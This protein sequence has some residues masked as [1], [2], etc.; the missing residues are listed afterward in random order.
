MNPI[1]EIQSF[2]QSANLYLLNKTETLP[3]HGL[4]LITILRGS[5]T[6]KEPSI[7]CG[8]K[9]CLILGPGNLI[10]VT[11]DDECLFLKVSLR[12]ECILDT[13]FQESM[14]SSS[15]K[16]LSSFE[17]IHPILLDYAKVYLSGQ[18]LNQYRLSALTLQLLDLLARDSSLVPGLPDVSR[19][20][21]CSK[22]ELLVE[23]VTSYLEEN[24]K[25]NPGL[26]K[27]AAFFSITPQYLSSLFQKY[28]NQ[29]FQNH[30][31][32]V[33]C[34]QG[35]LYYRYTDLELHEICEK[36]GLTSPDALKEY[37]NLEGIKKPVIFGSFSSSFM[38]PLSPESSLL[39]FRQIKSG[40]TPP[41][42]KPVRVYEVI[43]TTVLKSREVP[44]FWN[45]LINL[46]YAQDFSNVKIF[47]QLK[48]TQREIGFSYGRICRLFDLV[49]QYSISGRSIYDYNQI[50]QILDI[51]IENRML[52]FLELSNKLFRIHLS[53]KENIAKNLVGSTVS[54]FD[55]LLEILPDFLRAC[56][57]RYG[58]ESVNSW[59]FEIS[60]TIY[61][62]IELSEIFPLSKYIR[63]FKRL[64]EIIKTYAPECQVG[65][66][67][68][69]Q[70]NNPQLLTKIYE[71][72]KA[73][74]AA[75]DFLTAYIYPTTSDGADASISSDEDL[76]IKRIKEISEITK[77][78]IANHGLWITEF[79]SNISSRNLLN[80]S[81]FQSE[82][83][84]KN[85]SQS[86]GLD[87][88]ALGYYMLFD[89]PLRHSDS[90]DMLFGGWG[91][92][93]D[94]GIPKPSYHTY[95]MFSMLGKNLLYAHKNFLITADTNS[96]FRFLFFHYE[97]INPAF[98][99][100]NIQIEDFE[101]DGVFFISTNPDY[102]EIRVND[103][104]KG[105][106]LVKEYV[107]SD[108]RSNLL[109]LWKQM[110][111]ITVSRPENISVLKQ[112]S[113]MLPKLTTL[114]VDHSGQLRYQISLRRREV[115]LVTIDLHTA[116][117]SIQRRP[118]DE[119]VPK[120]PY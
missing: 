53:A 61:D 47:D 1:F 48:E 31:K 71:M 45:R 30:L 90:M 40:Q 32:G 97:H 68:F 52:P 115:K 112:N 118:S 54:Y 63:Y 106:Y 28:F 14:L 59:R 60:Y 117:A 110:N 44:G 74:Q 2:I 80:D 22:Q 104:T 120:S 35:A 69:N 114:E 38:K 105:T 85:L 79:N 58:Q 20:K 73:A 119:L 101:T 11:S 46:G 23:R 66:P 92:F 39:S 50:F 43:E 77:S 34:R 102:W 62:F 42:E 6:M 111:L 93:T 12:P 17:Q 65:G 56:I 96:S 26:S 88:E 27:T 18:T 107:I 86:Y 67:G 78:L 24:Y 15:A 10:N 64:K 33:Q 55:Q 84:A 36:V 83:L 81:S 94:S 95:H 5:M 100:R 116:P 103:A 76:A 19:Q 87:I 109:F 108:S 57:N 72:M 99:G 82:F 41:Q 9:D 4:D 8:P 70:W 37:F 91:L 75:P 16:F 25:E 51:M 49:S 13:M 113:S 3:V 29:T 7:C 21:E 89:V 98:T